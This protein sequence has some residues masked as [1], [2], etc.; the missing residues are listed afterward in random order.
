M[1][2][3]QFYEIR[4]E[5]HLGESWSPWLEDMSICH[6]KDGQTVLYGPLRDQAALHGVLMRIRDLGLPLL[7]V[8]RTLQKREQ[9]LALRHSC[10]LER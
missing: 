3:L 5:G 2:P 7:E 9:Y 6:T 4:I 8:K 1:S 10:R